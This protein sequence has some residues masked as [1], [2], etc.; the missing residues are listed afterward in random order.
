MS[1]HKHFTHDERGPLDR[2]PGDPYPEPICKGER[3]YPDT[4]RHEALVDCPACRSIL[5]RQFMAAW[6]TPER[7]IELAKY[8]GSH[9]YRSAY[10]LIVD[11]AHVGF[12]VYR[13]GNR[14][15]SWRL[16][17]ID[18][19][20]SRRGDD[21]AGVGSVIYS[22]ERYERTGQVFKTRE[23]AMLAAPGLVAAGELLTVEQ[24]AAAEAEEARR[25]AEREE[26]E[27]R[28]RV[29]R[30]AAEGRRQNERALAAEAVASVLGRADLTNA[31]R[32]GLLVAFRSLAG[33]EF[34]ALEERA[35]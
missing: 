13:Q 17:K 23:R 12:V 8:D 7:T 4:T 10:R 32:A 26:A 14:G 16:C 1:R 22:G 9:G 25:R 29:E 11:G 31:E 28:R 2:K 33:R 24:I 15:G 19:Y 18:T 3:W 34:D 6:S 30:E 27:Q 5:D 35:A 21:P 20:R